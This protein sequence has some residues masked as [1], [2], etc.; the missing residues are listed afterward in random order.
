ML[1]PSLTG[2]N[3]SEAERDLVAFPVYM[4]GLGL[5]NP[6]ASADAEYSASIRVSASRVSK[7]K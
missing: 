1:I 7:L 5:I 2:R 3:C 6:S 4:G